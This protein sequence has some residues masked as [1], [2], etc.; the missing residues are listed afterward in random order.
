MSNARTLTYK[1][2]REF[3]K[4]IAD[5]HIDIK[6]FYRFDIAEVNN[7]ISDKLELPALFLEAP[8]SELQSQTKMVS[9]FN[10]RN[11][12]FLILDHAGAIDD[13]DKKETILED[14]EGIA[15]DIQSY[16]IKCSKDQNH[17]LFGKFDINSVRIEKVGPLF[18]NMHGWNVL[19]AFSAHE[20]MTFDESKWNF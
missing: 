7:A 8:S 16:L 15:L 13:Y 19:Y 5:A 14:T 10:L 2:I 18:D 9:N 12:S 11:I 1:T 6:D 17:F 4:A 20:P 3:H